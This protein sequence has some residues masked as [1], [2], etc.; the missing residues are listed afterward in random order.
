MR[1]R[2]TPTDYKLISTNRRVSNGELLK[3]NHVM[4][5][6]VKEFI[7]C[8]LL[9]FEKPILGHSISARNTYFSKL[10]NVFVDNAWKFSH[11]KYQLISTNIRGSNREL[12][13]AFQVGSKNW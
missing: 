7:F 8:W 6:L 11:T 9:I 3:A 12:V 1:A 13:K 10:K 4:N 2:I 5:K